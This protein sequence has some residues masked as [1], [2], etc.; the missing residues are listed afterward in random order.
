MCSIYLFM[1]TILIISGYKQIWYLIY[2]QNIFILRQDINMTKIRS[3]FA[4]EALKILRK[5]ADKLKFT[6][7]G[8]KHEMTE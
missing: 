7:Q 5:Y 8:K 1:Y 6:T 4:L 3:H 2:P